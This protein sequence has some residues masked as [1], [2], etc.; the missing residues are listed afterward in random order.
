MCATLVL[1]KQLLV[2]D[3]EDLW[4]FF[5]NLH[6]IGKCCENSK[7]CSLCICP[8]PHKSVHYGPTTE[9]RGVN[10]NNLVRQTSSCNH[11]ITINQ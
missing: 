4:I 2:E 8:L 9:R 11:G 10:I 1:Q 7:S 5:G 3:Q 6:P